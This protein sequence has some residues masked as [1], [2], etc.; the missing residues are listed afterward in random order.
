M[1]VVVFGHI[2]QARRGEVRGGMVIP[3]S[4][5]GHALVV[6]AMSTMD[7]RKYSTGASLAGYNM[8]LCYSGRI[9]GEM[10]GKMRHMST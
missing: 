2:F 5:L 6:S 4:Y 8:I 10:L 3:W 1:D 7:H 9:P